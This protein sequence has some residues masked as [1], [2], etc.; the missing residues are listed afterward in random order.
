MSNIYNLVNSIADNKLAIFFLSTF[1]GF[2]LNFFLSLA[3]FNW[4]RT[5]NQRLIYIIFPPAMSVISWTISG[6]LGLSLGMIG[7]LSIVRFRTPVKSPIELVFYFVLIVIGISITV[8]PSYTVL[9]FSLVSFVPFIF[10][11]IYKL[12]DGYYEFSENENELSKLSIANFSIKSASTNLTHTITSLEFKLLDFKE[13]ESGNCELSFEV[14]SLEQY[15]NL[16]NQLI[17]CGKI[18]KSEFVS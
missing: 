4:V 13:D 5:L 14:N 2:M 7:A 17:K 11:Y 9:I 15:Q 3:G 8:A 12:E 16:K 10:K 18:Q 1:L 6:N